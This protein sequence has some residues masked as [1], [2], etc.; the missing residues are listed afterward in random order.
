MKPDT[1]IYEA[2]EMAGKRGSDVLYLDDQL[3]SARQAL[4]EAVGQ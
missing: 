2:L 1:K 4:R 3:E